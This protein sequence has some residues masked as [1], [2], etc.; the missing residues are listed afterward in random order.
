V[1]RHIALLTLRPGKQFS[2]LRVV[3]EAM[4]SLRF[5]GLRSL[6]FAPDLGIVPGTCACAVIIDFADEASYIAFEHDTSHA[7]IRAELLAPVVQHAVRCQ[8]LVP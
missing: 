2:D 5:D 6:M 1:I 8:I 3:E 7:R 4:R